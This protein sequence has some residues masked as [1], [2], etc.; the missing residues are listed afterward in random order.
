MTT[1]L[2]K[3]S[4]SAI[5]T[6]AISLVLGFG[7]FVNTASANLVAP[8]LLDGLNL[9]GKIVAGALPQVDDIPIK[10]GADNST[11]IHADQAVL[12]VNNIL[13]DSAVLSSQN[14]VQD[15]Y[16]TCRQ[17][18]NADTCNGTG[19]LTFGSF[20]EVKALNDAVA[21]LGTDLVTA[22]KA[23]NGNIEKYKVDNLTADTAAASAA[24][25]NQS[26]NTAET[27][28]G[29]QA[30][31]DVAA[32]GAGTN[33][34]TI[35][36]GAVKTQKDNINNELN[37][38]STNEDAQ[39][40]V[41][42]K[43]CVV[44]SASEPTNL[45]PCFAIIV[46]KVI[47]RPTSYVLMG[48]GYI[49]DQML[50]F[51]ID[52]SN[53]MVVPPFIDT[54]WKTARD[55]S[56][57][58]FIFVLLYTGIMT[59]FGMGEWAKT[60]RNVVIIALLINFSLFFTKII[61]DAGNILA[62]GVMNAMS[63]TSLSQ[64]LASAFQ[65]QK[66]LTT[67]ALS[68]AADPSGGNAIVVFLVATVVSGFAAYIFFKAAILFVRRL[69]VFWALM[70]LSPF[71]FISFTLPA[72]Y[73]KFNKW[74]KE[75]TN[76]AFIAPIF[77]FFMYIIMMAIQAGGGIMANMPSAGAGWF[78]A[79]LAPVL[80]AAILI[81]A[82][83]EALKFT[84]EMAGST[85]AQISNLVGGAM[86]M[87][88]GV[89]L[90]AVTGGTALAGRAV[91]GRA[92]QGLADSGKLAKLATSDN[93]AGRFLGRQAITLNDKARTGT[94]DV[95][96]T[97]FGKS[98]IG[99]AAG[100]FGVKMEGPGA[101][102][103]GGFEGAQK[104]QAEAD[105]AMA[106]KLKVTDEEKETIL[107]PE[108]AAE[109]VA[110][111]GKEKAD[112]AVTDA[113]KAYNDSDTA[114]EI[115]SSKKGVATAEQSAKV[116]QDTIAKA[117]KAYDE[118]FTDTGSASDLALKQVLDNA[119]TAGKPQIDALKAAE[120]KLEEAI[121][122][123]KGSPVAQA[124]KTAIK[125]AEAT[126][127]TAGEVLET[128]KE[129]LAK[130]EK[131]VAEENARRRGSY[132]DYVENRAQVI[133]GLASTVAGVAGGAIGGIAAGPLGVAAGYTAG[134]TLGVGTYS[135]KQ[136]Q[137]TAK[138]IRGTT[139]KEEEDAEKTDKDYAKMAKLL[140]EKTKKDEGAPAVKSA[141]PVSH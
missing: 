67:A 20:S 81:K 91:L 64:G 128:A 100:A 19:G 123:D 66:F 102:A 125:D 126:A 46:Y 41:L 135:N 129:E 71:A 68:G 98:T 59:M 52:N 118:G 104:R 54:I 111:T 30:N 139:V 106:K 89:A 108:K 112:K 14:I 15:A 122:D 5:L 97:A 49:F 9:T 72:E 58:L 1:S 45:T 119:K 47:Y 73:N 12:I 6:L 105:I 127:K 74:L 61:I 55:F 35:D 131:V 7:A 80:V 10:V 130:K 53:N 76:Q 50:S 32:Q 31:N 48:S 16:T 115:E 96:G 99:K 103:K 94:W 77:L 87:A 101:N 17:S 93:M 69:V 26:Q 95:S 33:T 4:T 44:W 60:V 70:I 37:Y 56:N 120:A 84:E 28:L 134:V 29:T 39:L 25:I 27:G 121:T 65:P 138:K 62:L 79:L 116:A 92:A 3:K 83:S 136:A 34:T 40:A 36:Q 90:G 107:G 109:G 88:G 75:L 2:H 24:A 57:M 11:G 113:Q 133:G 42:Q 132:A 137:A 78:K 63:T 124:L 22:R 141:A 23:E 8:I 51:S 21:K 86:G 18:Q 140:A 117:Q 110:K 38:T 82:M 85:G 43:A 13:A 114:K